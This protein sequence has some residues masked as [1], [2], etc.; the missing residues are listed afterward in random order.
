M[1]ICVIV[2][3]GVRGRNSFLC[4]CLGKQ[5]ILPKF[6]LSCSHLFLDLSHIPCPHHHA[7]PLSPPPQQRERG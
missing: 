1:S 5:I 3:V 6:F 4:Y 2:E 7:V